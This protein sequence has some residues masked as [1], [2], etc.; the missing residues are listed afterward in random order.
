VFLRM[1]KWSPEPEE[2]EAKPSVRLGGRASRG[3]G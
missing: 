3:L 1:K 2:A